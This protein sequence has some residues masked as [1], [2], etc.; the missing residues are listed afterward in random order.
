MAEY[1]QVELV[2]NRDGHPL[3]LGL[4]ERHPMAG[5]FPAKNLR[6]QSAPLEVHE[7]T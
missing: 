3:P 7:I 4:T 1:N 2:P 6:L 5:R